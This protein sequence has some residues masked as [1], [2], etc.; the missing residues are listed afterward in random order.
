MGILLRYV[1]TSRSLIISTMGACYSILLITGNQMLGIVLPGQAF[2][3]SYENK[4]IQARV[5]S[6][7]LEDSSTLGCVLIPWGAASLYLQGVLSVDI[8]YIPYAFLNYI[9]PMFS[10]FFAFTGIA[11]WRR[12]DG[13]ALNKIK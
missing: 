11:V 8:S 9:T 12:S 3:D 7:T 5:L 13:K 1:K 2:K 6:R 10:I 4:N